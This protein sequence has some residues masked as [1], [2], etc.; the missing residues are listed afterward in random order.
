MFQSLVIYFIY[1]RIFS[2][3]KI[4]HIQLPH[5][6]KIWGSRCNVAEGSCLLKCDTTVITVSH[7]RKPESSTTYPR[8]MPNVSLVHGIILL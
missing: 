1:G 2:V 6:F 4:E 5:T 8:L 3:E 7:P